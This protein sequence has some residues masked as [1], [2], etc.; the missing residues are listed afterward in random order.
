LLTFSNWF[1]LRELCRVL[2]Y[3]SRLRYCQLVAFL[4]VAIYVTVQVVWLHKGASFEQPIGVIN[5]WSPF[6]A[7]S[8]PPLPVSTEPKPFFCD[9]P[10]FDF[11][12]ADDAARSAFGGFATRNVSCPPLDSRVMT[13]VTPDSIAVTTWRSQIVLNATC[14]N[15]TEAVDDSGAA[16]PNPPSC[17]W[18]ESSHVDVFNANVGSVGIGF[19]HAASTSW[20]LAVT[21][22]EST[23]HQ[24][25]SNDNGDSS[26]GGTF[27]HYPAGMPPGNLTVGDL[28]ALAEV[29]LDAPN[30][31]SYTAAHGGQDPS[32]RVTG[33]V[34]LVRVKYSNLR[35]WSLSS[36]PRADISVH[37]IKAAWGTVGPRNS[38]INYPNV[39]LLEFHNGVQIRFVVEGELGRFDPF[40]TIL[41]IMAAAFLL[42]I[43]RRL[44][45][46][47]AAY[48]PL[49]QPQDR[50]AFQRAKHDELQLNRNADGS[51]REALIASDSENEAAPDYVPPDSS[52][53]ASSSPS[54]E[55]EM[56]LR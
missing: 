23:I 43:A 39:Q 5:V 19:Q 3:D 37:A 31:Q 21:N 1:F 34:L 26:S 35:R 25:R 30:P 32:F 16:Q 6:V 14:P 46:L 2:V 38:Y 29:D 17:P 13:T 8:A 47:V 15:A 44:V 54:S 53:A 27:A 50:R 33:C 36:E 42:T 49:L 10:A 45:D 20:G 28:L 41:Q 22:A 56:R 4:F 7:L 48:T 9:N 11:V 18:V 40:A 52:A 12:P 51:A 55:L 24:R